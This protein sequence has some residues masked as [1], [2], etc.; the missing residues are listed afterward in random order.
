MALAF[1]VGNLICTKDSLIVS[2][3]GSFVPSFQS[4]LVQLIFGVIVKNQAPKGWYLIRCKDYFG[5]ANNS[6]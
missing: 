2:S 5:D 4:N 3:P 6:F 1:L